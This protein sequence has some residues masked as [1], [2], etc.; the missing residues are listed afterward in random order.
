MSRKQNQEPM[1]LPDI[2]NPFKLDPA[3]RDSVCSNCHLSGEARILKAGRTQLDFQTGRSSVGSRS[4]VCVVRQTNEQ[5]H[6]DQSCG[7]ALSEPVPAVERDPTV[8]RELSQLRMRTIPASE[9][10]EHYRQKCLACHED[11]GC[12]SQ[13]EARA[14]AANNCFSCHMPKSPTVD[15][16]HTVFTDHSIPRRPPQ[17]AEQKFQVGGNVATGPFGTSAASSRDLGLAYAEVATGQKNRPLP[18]GV[19]SH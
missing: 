4:F 1:G 8:V 9:R 7:K 3:R 12:K 19:S 13:P 11:A 14:Q 16:G 6:G 18:S 17:L 2:V 10:V 5:P 15:V